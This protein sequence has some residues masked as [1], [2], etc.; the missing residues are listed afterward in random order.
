V[1][2]VM[3]LNTAS[4]HVNVGFPPWNS[5]DDDAKLLHGNEAVY[6]EL[7]KR[8]GEDVVEKRQMFL[9]EAEHGSRTAN[10]SR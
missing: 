8:Y 5:V 6:K 4:F 1:Y 7:V 9:A 3:S 2:I 10:S